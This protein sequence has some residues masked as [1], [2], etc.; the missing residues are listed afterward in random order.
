MKTVEF[1]HRLNQEIPG[2]E[3]FLAELKNLYPPED[4]HGLN[5]ALE[6][7]KRAIEVLEIACQE[8]EESEERLSVN[9]VVLSYAALGH[10][11]GYIVEERVL[12]SDKFEHQAEGGKIVKG[13]I[14]RY[15][16]LSKREKAGILMSIMFHDDI[17]YTYPLKSRGGKPLLT[18]K[19][20]KQ[21]EKAVEK[22]GFLTELKILREADSSLA[23]GE[24]GLKRTIEFSTRK[25][26]SFFADGKNPLEAEMWEVSITSNL[27]LSARRA[28]EDAFTQ[29]GKKEAIRGWLVQ[30][31]EI[32]RRCRL[33]GIE[34]Y[35]DPCLTAVIIHWHENS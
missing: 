7:E 16:F 2:R 26:L 24:V 31:K 4:V 13:I 5:H 30:E 8:A 23:N 6:V 11:V 33:E 28:F 34:Y 14:G 3:E 10:D 32:F 17:D 18:R 9:L 15:P 19:Q 22:L 35:L 21:R 1:E 25:G 12:S 27:R 20:I 29:E